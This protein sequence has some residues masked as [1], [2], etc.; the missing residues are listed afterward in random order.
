MN[1]FEVLVLLEIEKKEASGCNRI[2]IQPQ[3]IANRNQV[4]I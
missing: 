2:C 4:V 1:L 3:R